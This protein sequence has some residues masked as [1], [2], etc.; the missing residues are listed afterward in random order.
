MIIKMDYFNDDNIVD[1]FN[2]FLPDNYFT[3]RTGLTDI[4][5]SLGGEPEYF[6]PVR[7]C[8][9][10]KGVMRSIDGTIHASVRV[11]NGIIELDRMTLKI[12]LFQWEGERDNYDIEVKFTN[13]HDTDSLKRAVSYD[14]K[15]LA[16]GCPIVTIEARI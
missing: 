10:H 2:S 14:A 3:Y 4:R 12:D 13:Y 11:H 7:F 8:R 9:E 5:S 15:C 1:L 6:I 16:K